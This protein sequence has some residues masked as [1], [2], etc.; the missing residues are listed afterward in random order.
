MYLDVVDF[1]ACLNWTIGF[2]ESMTVNLVFRGI[3][4]FTIINWRLLLST[5]FEWICLS[6]NILCHT[7]AAFSLAENERITSPLRKTSMGG[8]FPPKQLLRARF[9]P[10][11]TM[12]Y[13][14]ASTY[15]RC[16]WWLPC[17]RK[18][19][20]SFSRGGKL[21]MDCDIRFSASPF[22]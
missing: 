10:I 14:C 9:G 21:E 8:R 2:P 1:A 16:T 22:C 17:S 7:R 5:H 18:F 13:M 3:S 4:I 6:T 11:Y 19:V 12:Y 15:L 20:F